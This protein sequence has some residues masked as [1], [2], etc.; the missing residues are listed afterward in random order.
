[1]AETRRIT[2]TIPAGL[3][4]KLDRLSS[5]CHISR[6]ALVTEL[7]AESVEALDLALGVMKTPSPENVRR[8]RGD[9][10]QLVEQKVSELKRLLDGDLFSGV[11]D[12]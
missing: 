12:D 8:Y 1:M 6:S 9:S 5:L 3:V 4:E 11:H 2:M 10:I 7:L